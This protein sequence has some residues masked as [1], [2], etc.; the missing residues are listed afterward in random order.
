MTRSILPLA[1][2]V[3]V[4]AGGRL[5]SATESGFMA[6]VAHY[7]RLV[8]LGNLSLMPGQDGLLTLEATARTYRHLEAAELALQQNKPVARQVTP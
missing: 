5:V 4:L 7:P 3:L 6:D 2:I 1:G 8:T